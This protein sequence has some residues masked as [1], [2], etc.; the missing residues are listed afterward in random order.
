MYT[1]TEKKFLAARTALIEE[2]VKRAVKIKKKNLFSELTNM[3][4]LKFSKDVY[5]LSPSLE[6]YPFLLIR[7]DSVF[8]VFMDKNFQNEYINFFLN[9][10]NELKLEELD[11]FSSN[12]LYETCRYLEFFEKSLLKKK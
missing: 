1:I 6:N 12:E 10:K 7:E 4:P 11:I 2:I 3:I 5:F 9:G 8:F